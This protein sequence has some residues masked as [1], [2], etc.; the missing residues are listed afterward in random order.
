MQII[1]LATSKTVGNAL[2]TGKAT[3]EFSYRYTN[4]R[5]CQIKFGKSR[6]I[7]MSFYS[8]SQLSSVKNMMQ[9]RGLGKE[10]SAVR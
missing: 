9:M 3:G 8:T 2:C 4:C 6:G 5:S 7:E 10:G 1:H